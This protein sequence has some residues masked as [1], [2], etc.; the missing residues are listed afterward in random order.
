MTIEIVLPP[1]S[2]DQ[3]S[4]DLRHLTKAIKQVTGNDN[5]YGILGGEDGYGEEFRNDTFE[6]HPFYWGDCT[7]GWD[8][9]QVDFEQNNPHEE[10]CFQ[11][12]L[13]RRNPEEPYS[14]AAKLAEERGLP[15]QGCAIHCDCSYKALET[16]FYA[17]HPSHESGCKI[18]EPNFVHY[19]S[20]FEVRW[21][22]YI[23]RDMEVNRDLTSKQW[24]DILE[25]CLMSLKTS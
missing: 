8:D 16:E 18:E 5:V 19:A 23:G 11:S 21:Y 22:K 6:M 20:N 12:E 3:I 13:K 1:I 2:D 14:E 15:M 7:C 24:N 4:N 25:E 9:M 10:H 17:E